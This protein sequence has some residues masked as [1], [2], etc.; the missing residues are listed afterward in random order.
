MFNKA[1]WGVV[2]FLGLA[3]PAFSRSHTSFYR[4]SRQKEAAKQQSVKLPLSELLIEREKTRASGSRR[5][6]LKIY[7]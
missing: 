7:E 1:P 3:V 4:E 5:E 6:M 2:L